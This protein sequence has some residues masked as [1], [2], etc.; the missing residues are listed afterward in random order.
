MSNVSRRKFITGAAVAAGAIATSYAC[1]QQSSDPQSAATTAPV[2]TTETASAGNF[3][4]ETT[5]AKLGFIALT[6]AAPLIIALE[7]GFYAKYGMTDVVVDKQASWGAT[8]DNLV[9]GSGSGGIDGAHILTPMPYLITT[10]AV[11]DGNPT[12]MYI[13]ARLNYNGQCIS[14]AT[15]YKDLG[16]TTDSSPLQEVFAQARAAGGDPKSAMTFP[17]GTHDLWTRYWL[18]AGGINP[19]T[20]VSLIVVPPAQM[21][22]NMSVGSM[23]TF[24]VCEPWNEQA[25]NQG[26]AVTALTTGELWND[27][28]EKAFGMRADWVDQNPNAAKALL[29]AVMEGQQWCDDPANAEEMCEI[30]AKRQ[31][32]NAPFDDIINRAKGNFEYGDGRPPVENHPHMMKFWRDNASYPYKSHDLWFLTENIRWGYLPSSTDTAALIEQVNREDLWREAAEALGVSSDQIPTSTS[33]GVETFADG[34]QFDPED[35]QA[36]L[37]AVAIKSI[38]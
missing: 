25:I 38:A 21:V 13:L 12:P 2:D 4:V 16:V 31:W 30:V 35:P 15:D 6:D 5:S 17:G 34:I 28:P 24:C 26:I 20:D 19:G 37:D 3:D 9:L 36:Y 27:H 23:D 29:M 33:R 1:A 11:T 8:R 18:A 32:I 7:K 22:A 14:I 10:G